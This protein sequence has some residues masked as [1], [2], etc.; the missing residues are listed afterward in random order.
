MKHFTLA[1]LGLALSLIIITPVALSHGSTEPEHGGV[2][3]IEHELAFELVRHADSISLYIKDHGEA[4]NTDSLTG[5]VM[6]LAAGKKQE[7]EL[8]P[9]GGNQMQAPISIP[10]DAKALVKVKSGDHHPVLVRYSF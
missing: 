7:A 1:T 9:A 8:K 3:Q 5:S 2:V 10:D 4:Y 6:V